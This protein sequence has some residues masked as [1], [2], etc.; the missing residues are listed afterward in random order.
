MYFVEIVV[1]PAI[2][3]SPKIK[4]E[5]VKPRYIQLSGYISGNLDDSQTFFV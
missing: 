3:L 2:L 4:V 1:L 5:L